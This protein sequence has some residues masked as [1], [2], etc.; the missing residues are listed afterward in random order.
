[1]GLLVLSPIAFA[2]VLEIYNKCE[3]DVN[4]FKEICEV[5]LEITNVDIAYKNNLADF[6][7]LKDAVRVTEKGETSIQNTIIFDKFTWDKDIVKIKA[8]IDIGSRNY[9]GILGIWDSTWLNSSCHYRIP[10]NIS[11]SSGTTPDD[12]Q[13]DLINI[14]YQVNM[15][16]DFR[17]LL[18]ANESDTGY[19]SH[20]VQNYNASGSANITV[21]SDTPINTTNKTQY[22]YI[23]EDL[24]NNNTDGGLNTFEYFDDFNRTNSDTIGWNWTETGSF[25]ANVTNGHVEMNMASGGTSKNLNHPVVLD[26]NLSMIIEVK[27][28][29]DNQASYF[30]MLNDENVGSSGIWA[31]QFRAGSGICLLY[32]GSPWT[33]CTEGAYT[34]NMWYVIRYDYYDNVR[35]MTG[36]YYNGTP[37]WNQLGNMNNVAGHSDAGW[38]SFVNSTIILNEGAIARDFRVDNFR[39]RKFWDGTVNAY[40][41][42]VETN[43]TPSPPATPTTHYSEIR[44]Y[45]CNNTD[46]VLNLT[47]MNSTGHFNYEYYIVPCDNGCDEDNLI[48]T[49][50]GNEPNL[51]NANEWTQGIGLIALIVVLFVFYRW[52]K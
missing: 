45:F 40:Y 26:Q 52:I 51:C 22:C 7:I 48:I 12:Y 30:V 4:S 35:T 38:G 20:W 25:V 49:F 11:T 33:D 18:F 5:E 37:N 31:V 15:T 14:P 44:D 34:Y 23:C 36:W 19:L 28:P 17:N 1:M 8:V 32:S 21:R 47:Y 39:V 43:A 10:Y 24:L 27:T 2:D 13:Y 50:W 46:S 41:G 16:P 6:M 29:A 3:I 9:F 42:D